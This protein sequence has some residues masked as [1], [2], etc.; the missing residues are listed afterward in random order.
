MMERRQFL[1]QL[2]LYL[3]ATGFT[4]ARIIREAM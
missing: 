4:C 1:R 3:S 2:G